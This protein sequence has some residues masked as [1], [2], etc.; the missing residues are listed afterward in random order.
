MNYQEAFEGVRI[1]VNLYQKLFPSIST[2]IYFH[3]AGFT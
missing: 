3:G 1:A 2:E